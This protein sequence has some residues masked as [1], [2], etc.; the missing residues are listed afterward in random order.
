MEYPKSE[1]TIIKHNFMYKGIKYI[2][3][4]GYP[5]EYRIIKNGKDTKLRV[6]YYG[7][8]LLTEYG[9]K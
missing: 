8:R 6:K 4:F 3:D 5:C 2:N 7:G 1:K 9:I